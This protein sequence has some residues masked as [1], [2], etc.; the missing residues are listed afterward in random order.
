M[1][2]FARRSAG[3]VA[4]AA[5][6][7]VM[8]AGC[9]KDKED[10]DFKSDGATSTSVM[11]PAPATT[12]EHDDDHSGTSAPE[13]TT[14]APETSATGGAME[15]KIATRNG[16][17]IAVAGAFLAKYTELGGATGPLG[18]PRGPEREAPGG[19]KMQEFEGGAIYSS[20]ETGT[21]VVWGEIRKAWDGQGGPGGELGYPT[22]DETTVPGGKQSEFEDGSIS[23]V[24]GN[25]TI[26]EK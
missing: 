4:A 2:H 5:L 24:D 23:W 13:T 7:T 6:I 10:K 18:E 21:H 16:G 26:T 3:I 25:I 17:E 20:P 9:S 22:S 15:T 14:A 12:E 19:G 8:V 11:A 1:H